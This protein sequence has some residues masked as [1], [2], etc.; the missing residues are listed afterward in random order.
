MVKSYAPT[1]NALTV[2]LEIDKPEKTPL[3]VYCKVTNKFYPSDEFY[4][5][6]YNQD[7]D[8][9]YLNRNSFRHITKEI[10]DQ[11]VRNQ[12]NGL[13]WISDYELENP[14]PPPATIESFFD[15][16]NENA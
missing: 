16:A 13:G 9:R 2:L 7:T 14:P 4:V 3:M 11:R 6:K 5:K 1:V 15:E 8:P 12:R 10:W